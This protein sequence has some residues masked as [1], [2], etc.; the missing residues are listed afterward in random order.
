MVKCRDNINLVDAVPMENIVTTLNNYDIGLYILEPTKF[1]T[2]NAIPNK[3]YDF[4]QA[5]LAIAI[6]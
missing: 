6:G 5:K 4:V 3:L 1:N 2:K